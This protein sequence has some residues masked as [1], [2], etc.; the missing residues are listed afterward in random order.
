MSETTSAYT[1][2]VI[3]KLK[4]SSRNYVVNRGQVF[5]QSGGIITHLGPDVQA[6]T[7]TT[8]ECR[9]MLKNLGGYMV[10]WTSGFREDSGQSEWYSVI[11]RKFVPLQ[12]LPQSKRYK[13]NRSI[14][15]FDA[16]RLPAIEL[17]KTGY[18]VYLD[19]IKRY[20]GYQGPVLSGGQFAENVSRD[21]AYPDLVD[22]WGLFLK[23]STTL[24]GYS[25]NQIKETIEAK[26]S[27]VK[28]NPYYFA[29]RPSFALVYKMNEYYLANCGFHYVN[30]GF[31]SI[32]HQTHFQ[33]T[34]INALGFER[35]YT[36][37]SIHYSPLLRPLMRMAYPFRRVLGKL[38]ARLAALFKQERCRRS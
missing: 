15:H 29:N 18:P 35:A 14:K 6:T 16:R 1:L 9:I 31:R 33:E 5:T 37:L 27:A 10:R 30:D 38:D 11:C 20:R 28:L 25:Q 3:E 2:R 26:Y 24:V 21:S 8:A 7:L 13:I 12:E 23:D 32:Y 17:A 34:L 36:K 19:A 4:A 22:N